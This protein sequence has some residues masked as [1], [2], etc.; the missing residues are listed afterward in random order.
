M[1]EKNKKDWFASLPYAVTKTYKMSEEQFKKKYPEEFKRMVLKPRS[2]GIT[3]NE[4][5]IYK[6]IKK[7]KSDPE[8][9]FKTYC[10]VIKK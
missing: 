5:W 6:E 3:G 10:K 8:Y 2:T 1:T 9:F 4:S 7:C